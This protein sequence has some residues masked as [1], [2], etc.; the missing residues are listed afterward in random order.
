VSGGAL[1]FDPWAVL[2]VNEPAA[3]DGAPNPPQAPNPTGDAAPCLGGLGGLGAGRS[4]VYEAEAVATAPQAPVLT[5]HAAY[6]LRFAEEA[7]AALVDREPDPVEAEERA[8]TG[9]GQEEA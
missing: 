5:P 4:L 6:L 7:Y 8:A 9:T 3:A 2:A 1:A